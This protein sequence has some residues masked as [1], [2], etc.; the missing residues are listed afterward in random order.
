MAKFALLILILT[1]ISMAILF[2]VLAMVNE[3]EDETVWLDSFLDQCTPTKKNRALAE[4]ELD[5]LRYKITEE[6]FAE[7]YVKFKN[8]FE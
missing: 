4:A 6:R 3:H 5:Q 1:C 7:L 8:T 2:I